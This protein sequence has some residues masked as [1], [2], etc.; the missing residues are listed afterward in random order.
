MLGALAANLGG[1]AA[2]KGF[3]S[4]F[5]GRLGTNLPFAALPAVMTIG[6]NPEI[7]SSEEGRKELAAQTIAGITSGLAASALGAGAS[8]IG[9]R[10]FPG[11]KSDKVNPELTSAYSTLNKHGKTEYG[12]STPPQDVRKMYEATKGTI[13]NPAQAEQFEKAYGTH[14]QKVKKQIPTLEFTRDPSMAAGNLGMAGDVIAGA[15]TWPMVYNAIQGQIPAPDL[16]H[17]ALEAQGIASQ[18]DVIDQQLYS[19][20]VAQGDGL[21]L[22]NY[23]PGTMFNNSGL[24]V[25]SVQDDINRILGV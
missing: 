21:P 19:R 14:I 25:G 2:T 12:I 5:V 10:V 18:Q 8:R 15:V 16:Y 3:L 24:P 11:L 13:K 1:K 4:E 9:N 23:A 17:D 22:A 6:T 7:L 20:M